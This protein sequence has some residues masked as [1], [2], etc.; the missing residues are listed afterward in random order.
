[1]TRF[2]KLMPPQLLLGLASLL[3]LLTGPAAVGQEIRQACTP[4]PAHLQ[5]VPE[6]EHEGCSHSRAAMLR[7]LMR[8]GIPS[9]PKPGDEQG[10]AGDEAATDVLHYTLDIEVDL[11]N[12]WIGGS[13]I[14]TAEVLQGP[15][16]T[17]EVRISDAF[18]LPLITVNGTEVTSNRL[19][20]QTILVD[21]DRAYEVGEQF[22][23]Y[24]EYNGYPYS[25][26]F[27]SIEF[28][29]HNGTPAAWTLS[30]TWFAYTWWPN[31]DINTDKA[32][33]DLS[34]TV[35][36]DYS[37]ASQ[38]SLVSVDDVG[39]GKF[40]YNWKT[41]YP[42]ATYLY[43][44]AITN[45]NRF[46]ETFNYDAYSMP[47]EFFIYPESDNS[48]NRTLLRRTV[49]MLGVFSDHYGLYP[50]IN[51]K[52]GIAQFAWG[53]GMEHQTITSQSS[54]SEWLSA[55]ELGH[56]WW[57]DMI[58]CATWNN[59]WLNEGFA[60]YSE[61][62]WH[63]FRNGQNR[64]ELI[65]Y[66]A[67]RRPS[68]VDGSV[69]VYDETNFGRIFSSNFSYRKAGWVLHMLRHVVGDDNFFQTLVDYRALYEYDAAITDDFVAV[70]ENVWGDDLTWFF[71]PWIYDIGAPE[72]SYG[73][74][75]HAVN[76]KTYIEVDLRQ[77]QTS[78]YPLFPMPVDVV[79]TVGGQDTFYVVWNDEL[80]EHLLFEV[81]ASVDS[82]TLDP[83]EWVL[84]TGYRRVTFSDG[85]PKIVSIEPLTNGKGQTMRIDVGFHKDVV[86][87]ASDISLV[88]DVVGTV[89]V[90]IEYDP[91]TFV[92]TVKAPG[93]LAADHYTLTVLDSVVDVDSGQ[94]LDGELSAY[95][96]ANTPAIPSGDGLAGGDAV[97][98]FDVA[99]VAPGTGGSSGNVDALSAERP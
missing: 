1:M 15:I 49:D 4:Q 65:N 18:A 12:A 62:I 22:D 95:R 69:Y 54:F 37:V 90:T 85:P 26:G 63:E 57:G 98:G 60:T 46:A 33:A 81:P 23:I 68:R 2:R 6:D 36:S 24:I 9:S 3:L 16:S 19:N 34:F 28:T 52:Y 75:Q 92:I 61:G 64:Q 79:T 7:Y 53:G 8:Q 74:Q 77:T 50:F 10:P 80:A 67:G 94:S 47:V 71:D 38:G 40:K 88:G 96:W 43:S 42:T 59:I 78:S 51:E 89:P 87:D 21:L 97:F 41:D 84:A 83:E 66:M 29:D 56:S 58:T 91:V 30:E 14:I 27:G 13:N 35:S 44:F 32:T 39:G 25:D 20:N 86:A 70:A 5:V 17:M 31:K 73:W 93:P 11:D 55:H 48:G 99:A 82:V 76:G 72:Y 45:Y